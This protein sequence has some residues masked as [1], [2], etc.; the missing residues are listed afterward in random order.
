VWNGNTAAGQVASDEKI[1]V[2]L[3]RRLPSGS[4]GDQE[5]IVGA[6]LASPEELP[7]RAVPEKGCHVKGTSGHGNA[8]RGIFEQPTTFGKVL[9]QPPGH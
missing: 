2:V 9:G 3:V 7:V 1:A 5:N 8:V 4:R 6:P